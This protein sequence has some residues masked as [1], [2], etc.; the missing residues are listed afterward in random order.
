MLFV[1]HLFYKIAVSYTV[2][3]VSEAPNRIIYSPIWDRWWQ[4][5]NSRYGKKQQEGIFSW[6]KTLVRQVV[7]RILDTVLWPSPVTAHWVACQQN[8][9]QT[10]EGTFSA[11]WDE[12]VMKCHLPH[13]P[14]S[15]SGLWPRR[16]L[17]TRNWHLPSKS[18]KIKSWPLQL[19]TFNAPERNSGWKSGM[20]HSV[21]W[22][23]LAEQAFR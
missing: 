15:W 12:M 5:C 8:L 2:K 17:P 7:Q 3:C 4:Q 20:R 22:E 6:T 9:C 18:S 19:L 14:K 23:K 11:L 1:F 13:S 16:A 21:L 10:W